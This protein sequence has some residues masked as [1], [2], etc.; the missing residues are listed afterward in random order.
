M[1]EVNAK[2]KIISTT[3]KLIEKKGYSKI[4]TNHISKEAGVSIGT[5]YYHFENGKPD[6]IKEIIKRGYAEFLDEF[7]LKSL[8]QENLTLFLHDFLLRYIK[9]HKENK[10][11]LIAIEMALLSNKELFQDLEYVYTELKLFPLISKVLLQIGYPK[12]D[13]IDKI[14]KMLLYSIDTIVH[15]HV[16]YGD[17][18]DTD[19]ELVTF[20]VEFISRF[21]GLKNLG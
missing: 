8:N 6:I 15:R 4:S 14:S 3:I 21:I 9:Q 10:S 11:L 1:T 16:I 5:L 13:D 2:D 20:L 19:E 18:V 7:K 12:K 17:L